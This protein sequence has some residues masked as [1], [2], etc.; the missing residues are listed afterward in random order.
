MKVEYL[1]RIQQILDN[2]IRAICQS[3]GEEFDRK[4]LI[5]TQILALE[6]KTGELAN[7]TKC[8]KYPRALHRPDKQKLLIRYLDC[9]KFLLS[10]GNDNQF[11]IVDFDIEDLL[12]L[13]QTNPYDTIIDLFLSIFDNIA[14]LKRDLFVENYISCLNV[15]MTIFKEFAMLGSLLGLTFEDVFSYYDRIYRKLRLQGRLSGAAARED[16]LI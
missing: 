5:K 12:N 8:Y 9:F 14:N 1:F 3:G 6:V 16:R 7:L 10:I 13:V 15:Y 11:N 2:E 4:H